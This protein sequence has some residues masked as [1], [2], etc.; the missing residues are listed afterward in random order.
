MTTLAA[1]LGAL[2][3][4]LGFGVGSELRQPLG[5]AVV[6]GLL[7]SQMLTLFTTPVI[8]LQLE[9]LFHRRHPASDAPALALHK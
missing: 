7:V 1:L 5:I 2:P 4:M 9:R 8:Y 3:L 6:G